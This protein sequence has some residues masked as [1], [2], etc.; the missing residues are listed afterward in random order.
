MN[1]KILPCPR[2]TVRTAA[3]RAVLLLTFTL[4]WL[5]CG[6]GSGGGSPTDPAVVHET[7]I[8]FLSFDLV[9]QARHDAGVEPQLVYDSALSDVARSYS[10]EMRD[11]GFFAHV[12]PDGHDAG[13]R[14]Q[15]AGVTYSVAGENLAMVT[16]ATDP[17]GFAHQEFMNNPPHRANILDPRY[18]HGGVG[19]ARRG[20]TYW[21]TQ[22]FVRR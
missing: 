9:N 1:G 22:L 17:A 12:D 5:A 6:G 20:S 15:Q 16:N 8:E 19:V 21:I 13:F 2:A 14:L 10:E 4:P 11:R 3:V 18:T 7:E